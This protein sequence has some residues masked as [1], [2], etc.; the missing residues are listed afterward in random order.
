MGLR[1]LVYGAYERRLAAR[2]PA[3]E[4]PAARR[5]DARRQPALGP[6]RRRR[7]RARPPA[8]ADN[9]AAAARLVRGGRRRGR[10]AVAALDRQPQPARRRARARC[11]RSSRRPSTTSPPSGRWRLHPVGALDLLPA[12]TAERLKDAADATRGRRRACSSTS[13]SATAAAA[14]SPTP[15]ARCSRSRPRR[16][17]SLEELAEVIDVEHIAEH[18]YT[19]GQPDPDLVIRTS[20]EQRLGGFL[21][22]QSA[23]SEFYFCE[24][25]LARLPARRLPARDPRLRRSASAASAPEPAP[26]AAAAG[27]SRRPRRAGN[28]HPRRRRAVVPYDRRSGRTCE[29]AVGKPA[30]REAIVQLTGAGPVRGAHRLGRAVPASACESTADPRGARGAGTWPR[31]TSP[32]TGCIGC[33]QCRTPAE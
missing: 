8:G 1:N 22:W 3:D 26:A 31:A 28:V 33:S 14:R 23:H 25:L 9:I 32:S 17:T 20:G 4:P 12:A 21:L 6:G 7:H 5:R 24:A 13:P 19:K 10:H 15:C 11:C 30:V 29:P 16:G 2:L 18:L 27:S